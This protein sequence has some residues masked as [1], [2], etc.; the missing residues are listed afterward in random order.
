MLPFLAFVFA[1]AL[2]FGRIYHTSQVLETAA[3]T[4]AT[5]A[6]GTLWVPGMSSQ[7]NSDAAIASVIAAGADLDPPIDSKQVSVTT[8]NSRT[9]LTIEYEFPLILG[10]LYADHVVKFE[11]AITINY[12]PRPGD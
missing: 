8:V 3:S 4:G 6:S 5:Y 7:A 1:A 12:A 9:V 11:R 2:D 10:V